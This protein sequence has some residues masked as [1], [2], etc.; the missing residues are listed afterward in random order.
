MTPLEAVFSILHKLEPIRRLGYVSKGQLAN[1]GGGE[2]RK[3]SGRS[4]NVHTPSKN[5]PPILGMQAYI[6]YLLG[7]I[8][9]EVTFCNHEYCGLRRDGVLRVRL[10]I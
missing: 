5:A 2:S 6:A 7:G 10:Q 1:R 3:V 9:S 4:S 8:F